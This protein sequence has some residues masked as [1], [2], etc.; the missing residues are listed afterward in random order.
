MATQALRRRVRFHIQVKPVFQWLLF[1]QVIQKIW[2]HFGIQESLLLFSPS[3]YTFFFSKTFCVLIHEFSKENWRLFPFKSVLVVL[4]K[5]LILGKI[6][7]RDCTYQ[8][9]KR[10]VKEKTPYIDPSFFCLVF[11][12]FLVSNKTSQWNNMTRYWKR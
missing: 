5:F 2:V 6:I 7:T 3:R 9:D 1:Y 12:S 10:R 4:E 8:R 11:F